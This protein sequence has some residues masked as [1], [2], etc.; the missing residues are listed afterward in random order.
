MLG[1]LALLT[2]FTFSLAIDRFDAR[3]QNVLIEANAIGTTY[4]RTQL[5]EEPHRTRISNLL[6]EYV[7]MRAGAGPGP[8][9][10]RASCSSA[11]TSC[12]T[13]LWTA[14]VAAFPSIRGYDFSSSYPRNDEPGDRHGHLTQDRA[15]GAR[16][17]GGVRRCCSST[18][19]S[20]PGRWATCCRTGTRGKLSAALVFLSVRAG[21]AAGARHRPS[22]RR[23]GSRIAAAHGA[24]APV[25]AAADVGRIDR[26][27]AP[28][29]PAPP[30]S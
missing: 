21:A 8:R 3:R 29:V 7:D 1:L 18:S 9:K 2:G 4:L 27:N 15:P 5:L 25:D 11:T 24:A 6:K 14:T 20:V 26:F 13:D 22:G 10:E 19:S 16:P 23:P 30:P 12:I 28:A 17:A